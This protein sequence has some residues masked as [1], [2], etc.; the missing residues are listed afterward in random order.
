MADAGDWQ[1]TCRCDRSVS[2]IERCDAR[3]RLTVSVEATDD[4]GAAVGECRRR[5]VRAG[6]GEAKR[7][8]RANLL[9]ILCA[10]QQS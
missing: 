8:E 3:S 6:I 1:L 5:R 9:G 7:S 4:D 10:K 2:R